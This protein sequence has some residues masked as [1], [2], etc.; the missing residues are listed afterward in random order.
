[1][2]KHR[3]PRHVGIIP[4]GN[5]R[6][7]V[8]RGLAKHE[9]YAHGVLPGL[10]LF[11]QCRAAGVSEISVY[12]FTKDNTK[13][14]GVQKEAFVEATCALARGVIGSGAQVLVVGDRDSPS[15]PAELAGF[16]TPIGAGPRVNL[17]VNYGWDWDLAGLRTGEIRSHEVSRVDMVIR[18]GGG[19]RLSGFLP[20]Q[21]VYADFYVEEALWPDCRP[22]H[23]D[24]AVAWYAEQD[25]TLGG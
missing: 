10:A 9:G 16:D 2:A 6:W 18:W 4:D 20:V 24:Q 22:V 13:R 14:A 7:A 17:L 25:R 1:M 12:C 8:E 19:R 5:R 21:S 3:V 15:F 23:F 11:E